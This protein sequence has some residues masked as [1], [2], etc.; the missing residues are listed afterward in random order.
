MKHDSSGDIGSL[1][2]SLKPK[3]KT[4]VCKNS[5]GDE[6]ANVNIFT[7]ISHTYFKIKQREPTS[8]NK[9]FFNHFYAMYP[10][11]YQKRKIR[12]ISPFKVN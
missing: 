7:T 11:N 3:S 9:C 12:A 2:L 1:Y 5:S 8:F 4:L 6:I 10:G